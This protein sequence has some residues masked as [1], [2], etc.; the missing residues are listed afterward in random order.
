MQIFYLLVAV[1]GFLLYFWAGLHP[2][3]PNS[4]VSGSH[5]YIATVFASVAFYT[6]YCACK[7]APGRVTK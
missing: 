4:Q 2:H 6:Y 3:F 7:V 1:G 5:K